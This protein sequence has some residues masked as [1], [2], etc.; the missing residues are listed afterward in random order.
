MAGPLIC[1]AA[2]GLPETTL[3]FNTVMALSPPPP[4]AFKEPKTPKSTNP[5]KPTKA[6]EEPIPTKATRSQ[7]APP[8]PPS[9]PPPPPPPPPPV[10][11]PKPTGRY[12]KGQRVSFINEKLATSAYVVHEITVRR[13]QQRIHFN[14]YFLLLC[15]ERTQKPTGIDAPFYIYV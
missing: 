4:P 13:R 2:G 7:K 10:E 5:P 1:A 11:E 9:P 3:L 6:L 14:V 15:V 12:Y 8:P